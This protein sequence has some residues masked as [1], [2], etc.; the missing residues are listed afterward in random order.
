[1]VCTPPQVLFPPAPG[2]IDTDLLSGDLCYQSNFDMTTDVKLHNSSTT[3]P[4]VPNI[5]DTTTPSPTVVCTTCPQCTRTVPTRLLDNIGL[6]PH[7][8]IAVV[9]ASES[10]LQSF[11]EAIKQ[12]EWCAAM[13][14][15]LATLE[16][17]KTWDIILFPANK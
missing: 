9:L 16:A 5:I 15:E 13:N 4:V 7:L 1:M 3:T 2:F 12:P 6:P 10:E 17:T 14:L 8:V 11:E